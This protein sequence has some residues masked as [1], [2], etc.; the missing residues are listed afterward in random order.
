MHVEPSKSIKSIFSGIN[1][2]VDMKLF[3][4]GLMVAAFAISAQAIA[5]NMFSGLFSDDVPPGFTLEFGTVSS[6]EPIN[7]KGTKADQFTPDS[8]TAGGQTGALLSG[9]SV[10]GILVGSVVGIVGSAVGH[11]MNDKIH[12]YIVTVL[13]D[14]GEEIY[15]DM[16]KGD[17][18]AKRILL[19]GRVQILTD[20]KGF[21]NLL[22][23][24]V[25]KEQANSEIVRRTAHQEKIP[26]ASSSLPIPD[27]AQST[28]EG[29]EGTAKLSEIPAPSN[30]ENSVSVISS[31]VKP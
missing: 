28:Q 6:M 23:K 4:Y 12:G 27:A 30:S 25:S 11:N 26:V 9:G 31:E 19:N 21:I 22:G 3:K 1:I 5:W 8:Y 14:N 10:A 18:D 2:G 13:K 7:L 29:I 20:S 15:V 16:V 24:N 17:T